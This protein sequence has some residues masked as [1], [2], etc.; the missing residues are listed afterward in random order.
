[1]QSCAGYVMYS[2]S[3]LKRAVALRLRKSPLDVENQTFKIGTELMKDVIREKKFK[4]I[5]EKKCKAIY[6]KIGLGKNRT[7]TILRQN[8]FQTSCWLGQAIKSKTQRMYKI[9]N[10]NSK[11]LEAHRSST[12]LRDTRKFTKKKKTC[13]SQNC[14]IC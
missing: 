2:V 6:S 13:F 8:Y 5:V 4:K 14:A 11:Y 12:L 10:I 9:E 7:K 1:M 3:D